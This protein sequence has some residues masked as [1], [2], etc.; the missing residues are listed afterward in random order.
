MTVLVDG[1]SLFQVNLQSDSSV[2]SS[3]VDELVAKAGDIDAVQRHC[4]INFPFPVSST[5]FELAGYRAA[6][7]ILEGHRVTLPMMRQMTFELSGEDDPGLRR[8]L[9]EP[10]AFRGEIPEFSMAIGDREFPLGRAVIFAQVE[11]VDR[12]GVLAAMDAKESGYPVRLRPIEG[13]N[14]TA[15][16]PD[17]STRAP[18]EPIPLT[19]WGLQGFSEPGLPE[20][21]S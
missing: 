6:H 2:D 13:Q 15:W 11:V 14:F 4:N 19:R 8:L 21:T 5:H 3:P 1:A 12:D 20:A 7:L 10:S 17:R 9:A 16:M 18:D